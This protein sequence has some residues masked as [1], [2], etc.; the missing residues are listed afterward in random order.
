MCYF[1]ENIKEW[2]FPTLNCLWEYCKTHED[3]V[4]Y[5]HGK[6]SSEFKKC[7]EDWRHYLQ[8]F[9][10]EKK[11]ECLEKLKNH[12]IVGCNWTGSHFFG[13]FWWA[14]ADYIRKLKTPYDIASI[15]NT[16]NRPWSGKKIAV[17][18]DETKGYHYYEELFY[19]RHYRLFAEMWIG[20]FEPVSFYEVHK[21]NVMHLCEEY[22]EL[23]YKSKLFI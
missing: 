17:I 13:N 2:E 8:Y 16:K 15:I 14:R 6:G 18:Y 4:L 7:M 1:S 5:I 11:E 22:N 9:L 10:I 12:D 20:S 19:G 3:P 21:S 23:N